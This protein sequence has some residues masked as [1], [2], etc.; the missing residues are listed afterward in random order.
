MGLFTEINC[1]FLMDWV[2][3][4][5]VWMGRVRVT[6]E[7][8]NMVRVLLCSSGVGEGAEPESEGTTARRCTPELVQ[9]RRAAVVN[10]PKMPEQW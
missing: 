10:K 7:T 4:A 5:S 9:G 3:E 6:S 2:E 1:G 8:K